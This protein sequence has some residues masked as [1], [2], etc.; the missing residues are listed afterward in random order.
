[1]PTRTETKIAEALLGAVAAVTLTPALPVAWPNVDFS[2][3]ADGPYLKV[4]HSPGEPSAASSGAEGYTRYV[5]ILQVAVVARKNSGTIT[6][7][8]A[9]AEIAA[10][11]EIGTSIDADG[12]TVRIDRPPRVAPPVTG[13]SWVRYP[14]T[15]Q[16]M[17]FAQKPSAAA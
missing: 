5:G 17:A 11:F 9:A 12:V 7:T 8:K 4:E 3:P 15:I 14:V 6:P 10:A 1:M 16:Y 13:D 2:P